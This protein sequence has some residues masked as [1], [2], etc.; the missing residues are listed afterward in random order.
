MFNIN[1]ETKTH[2]NRFVNHLPLLTM[3]CFVLI[4][5]YLIQLLR[6]DVR[7]GVRTVVFCN[8]A[9]ACDWLGHCLAS[10]DFS[11]IRLHGNIPPEV[12][13]RLIQI[14]RYTLKE[15]ILN[16]ILTFLGRVKRGADYMKPVANRRFAL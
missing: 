16:C 6:K 9:K 15:L 11:F 13:Y 3:V 8:S 5:D 4:P 12:C 7:Q 2:N 1:S 14:L 10:H